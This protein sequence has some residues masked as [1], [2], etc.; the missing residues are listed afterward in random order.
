MKSKIR[1]IYV[2]LSFAF[3]IFCVLLPL[4]GSSQD[5]RFKHITSNDGLSQNAV[6]AITQDGDG[7]MWFGTKD[8]LNKYDGYSFAV[9][10]NVPNDPGTIDSNYITALFTDSRGN[11][12]VGTDHGL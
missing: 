2:P 7:F 9:Y 6:L 8:G 1:R 10:Q 11:L 12:W 3:L 4:L 5:F